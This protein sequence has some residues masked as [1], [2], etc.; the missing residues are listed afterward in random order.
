MGMYFVPRVLARR[1]VPAV[2][3][4]LLRIMEL[5][6]PGILPRCGEFVYRPCCHGMMTWRTGLPLGELAGTR[7]GDSASL[8]RCRDRS[9]GLRPT[10]V[11]SVVTASGAACSFDQSFNQSMNK[12]IVRV[13]TLNRNY[14]QLSSTQAS[15]SE[16]S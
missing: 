16:N 6:Q 3:S 4:R 9:S 2:R 15:L 13:E 7:R 14:E 5:T 10:K 1:V 12:V 8:S 11:D